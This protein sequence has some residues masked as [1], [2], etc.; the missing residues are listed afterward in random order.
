VAGGR[1][2]LKLVVVRAGGL[3]GLAT[4]TELDTGELDA[5]DAAEL[6]ERVRRAGLEE[7]QP[8]PP[9]PARPPQ[10]DELAY[11]L[12][13]EDEGQSHTVGLREG[14]LSDATRALVQWVDAHPQARRSV[15]RPGSGKGFG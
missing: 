8:P 2:P 11:E 15:E 7:R 12:T 13:V 9:G 14:D 6:S 4:R 5:G 10:P 1:R 3:A